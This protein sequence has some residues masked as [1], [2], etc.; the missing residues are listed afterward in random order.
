MCIRDRARKA[1]LLARGHFVERLTLDPEDPDTRANTELVIRR[2]RELDE[3]ERA[4]EEQEQ[5]EEPQ[6]GSPEGEQQENDEA[7]E[8]EPEESEGEPS[9]SEEESEPE[10]SESE[11]Q[12][13]EGEPSASE[14]TELT[15][16]AE[17]RELEERVLTQEEM[18]RLLQAFQQYQE[19]GAELREQNRR[20]RRERVDRDWCCL[21]YTSD[22][23]DE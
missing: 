23:A 4:R 14:E 3:I 1:Y 19:Q 17:E 18:M 11:E 10:P 13:E 15:E 5:Q 21:L 7:Q 2:L 16:P 6:E 20:V 12:G 9:G 8:G 22:A